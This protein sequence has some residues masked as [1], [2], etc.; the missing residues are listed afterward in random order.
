MMFRLAITLFFIPLYVDASIQGN[1]NID[2]GVS[3]DKEYQNFGIA[4]NYNLEASGPNTSTGFSSNLQVG[5]DEGRSLVATAAHEYQYEQSFIRSEID[6]NLRFYHPGLNWRTNFSHSLEFQKKVDESSG[7]SDTDFDHPETS[8]SVTTG[9]SFEYIKSDWLNYRTEV[10]ASKLN[11]SGDES[12]EGVL[13][14]GIGKS[15][16]HTTSSYLDLSKVCTQ[17]GNKTLK[18]ECREEARLSVSVRSIRA[19]LYAEAGVSQQGTATT[20]VYT[21]RLHQPIN[22]YS[23][24]SIESTKSI[25]TISEIDEYDISSTDL[26][27]SAIKEGESITYVY[28]WGRKQFSLKA[29]QLTTT[30]SNESIKTKDAAA[31]YGYQL[32]SRL[33]FACQVGVSYE[34]SDYGDD[35]T[36][37]IRGISLIKNHSRRVSSSISLRETTITNEFN[38]WSIN[39]LLSIKSL[40]ANLRTR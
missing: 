28:E 35:N 6:N 19:S 33:C 27:S 39:F 22:S 7:R 13:S 1:G 17:Y 14:I 37:S 40:I 8:W 30:A 3:K 20:N 21:L 23:T 26:F 9:P 2:L 32:G 5:S 12:H 38:T 24:F 15:I 29:R 16:T 18:D 4:A 25:D 10:Q 31:Y 11:A 36:Q 34:Y